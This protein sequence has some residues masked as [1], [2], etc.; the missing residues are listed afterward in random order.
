MTKEEFIRLADKV[1]DGLANVEELASFN[2]Y[3][4]TYQNVHQE[5]DKIVSE[6]Q[7]SLKNL[8]NKKITDQI[9][10]HEGP[11]KI[12]LWPRIAA[13][14]ILLAV[15]SFGIYFY[16]ASKPKQQEIAQLQDLSPGGN[17]AYLTL[18]NGKKINLD[19]TN[20]SNLTEQPGI[21]ITKTSD[22]QLIYKVDGSS[23]VQGNNTIETPLGGQYQIHLPD[24]TKVWLNAASSMT[25]PVKFTGKKRVVEV[26]GEAYFE[27]AHNADMP[28]VVKTNKQEIEVLGTHFNVMAYADEAEVQTTLLEGSVQI[29]TPH[30][31]LLL[32]PGQQAAVA[33]Q[34]AVLNLNADI[35]SAVAWKTGKIQFTDMDIQHIMRTLAR[36]YDFE[37]DYQTKEFNNTFGGS[38]SRT[39][40]LS[41]ILKSLESTGD[42]HFKIEGRR[43]IVTQ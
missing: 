12:S 35:E 25:Y 42:F 40:N 9:S 22:G 13:A 29:K 11:K 6:E 19:N 18:A 27:V 28:F 38:F 8:L 20:P 34:S 10:E 15:L 4:N 30:N 3:Y 32:K 7:E 2:H 39:K 33:D 1:S 16:Q 26:K 36:W 14:A 21:T 17:K 5:W 24:G 43:V 41:S 37:V 23:D 31:Y